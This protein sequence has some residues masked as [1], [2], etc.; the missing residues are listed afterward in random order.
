MEALH[1]SIPD[2]SRPL[3]PDAVY[4]LHPCRRERARYSA[5]PPCF[6]MNKRRHSQ[7]IGFWGGASLCHKAALSQSEVPQVRFE[8]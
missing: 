2:L 1:K 5:N 6:K 8:V 4:H 3:V 7:V